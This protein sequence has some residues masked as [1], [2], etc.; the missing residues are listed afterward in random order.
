MTNRIKT[1]IKKLFYTAGISLT[2]LNRENDDAKYIQR[3]A[4]VKKLAKYKLTS[5]E[6][7]ESLFSLADHCKS[8]KIDGDFVECGTYKGGTAS[9]FSMCMGD[10]SHLCLYDSFNS[11]PETIDKDGREGPSM[12]VRALQ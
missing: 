8:N 5:Q 2:R 3:L 12:S 1:L 9:V 10:K 7:I 11:M 4:N 6:S